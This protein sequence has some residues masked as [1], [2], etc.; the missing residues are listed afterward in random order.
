MTGSGN[1]GGSSRMSK[2]SSQSVSPVMTSFTPITAHQ[3][4]VEGTLTL[5][6][7]AQREGDSHG[8]RVQFLYPSSIAAYGLPNLESK[9]R[10]GA[11][12]DYLAIRGVARERMATRGYGETAPLYFPDDTDMKKAA[13][14]RV[15]IKIVPIT[16]GS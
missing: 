13:N 12:A 15:E 9:Q 3:V 5:L 2:S 1:D 8:R 6:E 7:F 14:R 11:V 4:N 10:A 16:E